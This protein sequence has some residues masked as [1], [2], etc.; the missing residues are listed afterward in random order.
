M[1]ILQMGGGYLNTP[2]SRNTAPIY[3]GKALKSPGV[4]RCD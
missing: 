4:R 1:T 2:E 3:F